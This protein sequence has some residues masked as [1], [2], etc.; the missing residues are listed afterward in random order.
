MELTQRAGT[1]GFLGPKGTHSEEV[2][3]YLDAQYREEGGQWALVPYTG[4]Y[5]VICAV[6]SGQIDCGVVPVENSI[7]GSINI[8]L[9]TLAH[10]V[11]LQIE[12]EIIWAVHNQLMVKYI[13]EPV[14]TILSH[15]QPLAQCR[16]YLK[17]HY[18]GAAIKSISSTAKAAEIVAEGG[19][20]YAA[21]ATSR[22]GK[23]YGL[24]AIATEIQDNLTNCTRFL[25]LTKPKELIVQGC[26]KT[27][28][29]C[30]ING[31]KAGSLCEVL[32]E[33]AKREVNLTRIESRPARTGLGE[34]IFF[35]DLDSACDKA[36]VKAAIEAL[37]QK[38][39]WIKNLGSFSVIRYDSKNKIKG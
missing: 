21:I 32:L 22:A 15:P 39:L 20:G 36:N 10:D 5:D 16:E 30:Q 27:S 34:Y 33:F 3:L 11:D 28:L 7:E 24:T 8:T 38:S 35:L 2:A 6:A 23:L 9:D 1:L 29:I 17:A 31:E 4:I 13:G 14:T 12:Q 37:M 19:R 26:D 18:G 25:V